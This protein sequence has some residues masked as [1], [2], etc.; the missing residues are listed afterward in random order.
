MLVLELLD[1]GSDNRGN[2]GRMRITKFGHS[3]LLIEEG[4]ARILLDP[5]SYSSGFEDLTELDAILITHDHPDHLSAD[6]IKAL[7]SL[8]PDAVVIADESSAK[9]LDE[10]GV[11]V[12]AVK[13]GDHPEVKGV[14]IQ[15]VGALHAEIH[16]SM[17]QAV[18]VGY[19]IG[20]RFFYPGDA[21][22]VPDFKV[23]IL[24]LP[25]AAPWSKISETIDYLL[26]IKPKFAI[27]VHDGILSRPSLFGQML[28]RF[29]DQA[30]TE[31]KVLEQGEAVE[32]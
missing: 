9:Q 4:K 1:Y 25:A 20:E 11:K 5:G 10:G 22:T 32:L 19:R 21:L 13:A 12:T 23:E 3:C 29:S 30:G 6:N 27:P 17:P 24:A 28:G 15:V 26:E 14:T 8:N 16:S 2:G 18:N 31:L 7:I